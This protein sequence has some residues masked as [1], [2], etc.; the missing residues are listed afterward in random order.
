MENETTSYTLQP[1]EYARQIQ[2]AHSLKGTSKE[3]DKAYNEADKLLCSRQTWL[4]NLRKE[5]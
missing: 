3:K 5:S 4:D 2:A 1:R